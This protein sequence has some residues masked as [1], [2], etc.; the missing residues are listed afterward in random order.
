MPERKK[1]KMSSSAP[2]RF[3]AE[4]E[5]LRLRFVKGLDARISEIESAF[6]DFNAGTSRSEALTRIFFEAH[7]LVGIAPSFGYGNIGK[8]ALAVEDVVKRELKASAD[9]TKPDE[10]KHAVVA[11]LN[12]LKSS[13]QSRVAL[14][15]TN[16]E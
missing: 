7:S 15:P 2:T 8:Q 12:M 9:S 14:L 4:L 3:E 1:V 13:A 16:G 11:L 5:R 10:L 6:A